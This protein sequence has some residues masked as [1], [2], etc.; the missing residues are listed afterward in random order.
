MKRKELYICLILIVT[1]L[2]FSCKSDDVKEESSS[3]N[4]GE[5]L[6]E[7]YKL[8]GKNDVTAARDYFL[9][10]LKTIGDNEEVY[11]SIGITYTIEKNYEKAMEYYL[12]ALE[13]LPDYFP[14]YNNVGLILMQQKEY[15]RAMEYFERSIMLESRQACA[16]SNKGYLLIHKRQLEAANEQFLELIKNNSK[17]SIDSYLYLF[18]LSYLISKEDFEQ[19]TVIIKEVEISGFM[20]SFNRELLSYLKGLNSEEE[21][22][23]KSLGDESELARSYLYIGVDYLSKGDINRGKVSLDK[24]VKVGLKESNP[25]NV[26]LKTLLEQLK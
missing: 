10:A 5:L 18:L 24:A 8:L 11:N 20:D 13:V 16:Y 12:M 6:E 21:L 7:G 22:I 17:A 19:V 9:D 1:V 26:I 3:D 2:F 4:V 25:E 15:D 14:A 23:G